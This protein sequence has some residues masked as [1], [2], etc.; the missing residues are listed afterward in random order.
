MTHDAFAIAID[1]P[2]AAGK[3]TIA[4]LLAKKL[5]GFHLNTG[6]MYRALALYCLRHSIDVHDT[7]SVIAAL[8]TI[9]LSVDDQSILMDGQDITEEIKKREVTEAV[10]VVA[11]ITE[12]RAEMVKRQRAI[13]LEKIAK[14]QSVIIDARDGATKIFPDAKF[15]IFLTASAEVRAKRRFEQA[16]Q[17]SYGQI[18]EDIKNRDYQDTHRE[19]DPLVS[20]PEAHG[21]LVVDNSEL[22]EDDT[23]N[24][25]L[26]KI[27]YDTH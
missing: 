6:A 26:E 8:G 18:L 9:S 15:K 4:Q 14:G 25:I 20:D 23:I 19:A 21:Y 22:S 16:H 7:A 11:A 27:G 13:G 5:H 10:P 24:L 12:V 3:G 2:V 17:G 1:G